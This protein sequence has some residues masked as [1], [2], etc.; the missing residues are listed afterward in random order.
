MEVALSNIYQIVTSAC[1]TGTR[2]H[3]KAIEEKSR[4]GKKNIFSTCRD[5]RMCMCSISQKINGGEN[6]LPQV[7]NVQYM[8]V[9]KRISN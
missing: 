7:N 1:F 6:D 8:Q 3:W 2:K 9:L 4:E 5:W